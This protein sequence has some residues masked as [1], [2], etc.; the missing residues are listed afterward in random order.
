MIEG[1]QFIIPER[2]EIDAD[3]YTPTYG[4]FS[5]GPFER[6]WGTT[7]GNAFR[8]ILLSSIE[9]AAVV[10][11]RVNEFLHEFANI[12]GVVEDVFEILLNLRH[13]P[14]RLHSPSAK[15]LYLRADTVGPV[16]AEMIEHDADVDI[17]DPS[18]YIC[19]LGDRGSIELE[20]IV[21]QGRGFVPA[22]RNQEA[23]LP[24]GFIPVA[25]LH[26]PVRKVN[27]QVEPERVGRR[28]EYD[29]ITLEI[30]TNGAVTPVQALLQAHHLLGRHLD[31]FARLEEPEPPAPEPEVE[32]T[33][34]G[35]S[36]PIEELGLQTR[37]L[38]IL[39][40]HHIDTVQ[41]LLQ[42]S[43]KTL[44]KL[45]NLGP[46]YVEQ[47]FQALEERGYLTVAE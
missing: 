36:I 11:V 42:Y 40:S 34:A 21:R 5:A 9:G 20:M 45:P 1:D 26:S 17:V 39:H 35:E 25:S 10:A 4:R 31:I 2:V 41:D 46:K 3:S 32:E 12:P 23:D 33:P 43:P 18:H 27:L 13:L 19:T 47:I 29:R 7:V 22:E 28:T 15:R 24:R 14:I 16:T 8:R 37:I 44:K 30:W 38:N 6:G